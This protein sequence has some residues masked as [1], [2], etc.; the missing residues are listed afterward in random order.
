MAGGGLAV[1]HGGKEYPGKLTGRVL[2]T[3][4]IA[5]AGG[6]IFG[7][8]LGIS[9]N[10]TKPNPLLALSITFSFVSLLCIILCKICK[11]FCQERV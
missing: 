8:D 6:L 7:Y 5:A 4:I 9:G 11:L 10:Q 2:V 1:Q 3:C